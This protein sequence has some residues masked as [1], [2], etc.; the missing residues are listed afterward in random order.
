MRL[1]KRWRM[2][3]RRI[4]GRFSRLWWPNEFTKMCFWQEEYDFFLL[5]F[6]CSMLLSVW[7]FISKIYARLHM[8]GFALSSFYS[9]LSVF[10]NWNLFWVFFELLHICQ[11]ILRKSIIIKDPL[12]QNKKYNTLLNPHNNYSFI[13]LKQLLS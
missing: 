7:L 5:L 13:F 12:A 4:F 6:F 2:R 11:N 3:C 8:K 1:A 9:Y 10:L